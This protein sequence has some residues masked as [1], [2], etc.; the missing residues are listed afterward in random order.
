MSFVNELEQ[1]EE[2]FRFKHPYSDPNIHELLSEKLTFIFSRVP[3]QQP[4]IVACIGTDRSTG[5]ALGPLV[6]TGLSR[7]N[8]SGLHLYGTLDNPVHALN[9]K[10]TAIHIQEHYSHPFIVAVDACLGKLD[11]VGS[12][13]V[14]LGPVRPGAGVKKDLPPIGNMHI[15]GIVNIGGFMEYYVLQNTRLSVVI[16]MAEVIAKAISVSLVRTKRA[17]FTPLSANAE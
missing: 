13:Q 11:S 1:L 15:T 6:G 4:I 3:K 2:Q 16:Q 10:E 7:M 17:F 5:D 12:I 8:L 14:G 9:L